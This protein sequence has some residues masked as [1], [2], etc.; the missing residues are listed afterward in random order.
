MQAVK[1]L[2]HDK[3][4]EVL[5]WAREIQL[6]QDFDDASSQSSTDFTEAFNE[7]LNRSARNS[8]ASST[9]GETTQMEEEII[10]ASGINIL[11]Q[12]EKIEAD[13]AKIKTEVIKLGALSSVEKREKEGKGESEDL[14]N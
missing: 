7:N 6:L 12:Q 1:V 14:S 11:R 13:N 5:N 10:K 2:K 3:D 4:G 9:D 8:S